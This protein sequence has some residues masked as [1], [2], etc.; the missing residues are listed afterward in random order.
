MQKK[1]FQL[2]YRSLPEKILNVKFEEVC[3]FYSERR[4]DA[5]TE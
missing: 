1:A 3:C 2:P 4:Q 5:E